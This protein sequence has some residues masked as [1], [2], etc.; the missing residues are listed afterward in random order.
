VADIIK[1]FMERENVV[2]P[3]GF[4]D[5]EGGMGVDNEERRGVGWGWFYVDST[6][7]AQFV[8]NLYLICHFI[9]LTHVDF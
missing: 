1:M 2:N 7:W 5:F 9:L 6:H 3:G 8:V 4:F